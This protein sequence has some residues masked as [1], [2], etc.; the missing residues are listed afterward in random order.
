M[1]EAQPEAVAQMA[2]ASP[3]GGMTGKPAPKADPLA[4]AMPE[5]ETSEAEPKAAEKDD[6]DKKQM[7]PWQL[8]ARALLSSNE[9]LFIP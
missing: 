5:R 1:T 4:D 6:D 2:Y 9:F 3:P 7:T 8:Y